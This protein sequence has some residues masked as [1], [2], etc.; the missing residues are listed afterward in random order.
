MLNALQCRVHT[1]SD[2]LGCSIRR[3]HSGLVKIVCDTCSCHFEEACLVVFMAPG[4]TSV[5]GGEQ[6]GQSRRQVQSARPGRA[7]RAAT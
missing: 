6:P 1:W 4:G 5:Q 2:C 7:F 3:I